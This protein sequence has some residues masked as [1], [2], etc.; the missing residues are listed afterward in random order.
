M[1]TILTAKYYK[2]I[3]NLKSVS[4]D[5]V[6][7]PI[8][9]A[10]DRENKVYITLDAYAD[11]SGK[12]NSILLKTTKSH[13]L[14]N[15]KRIGKAYDEFIR[16]APTTYNC[17]RKVKMSNV[18]ICAEIEQT[19]GLV[20]DLYELYDAVN[21]SKNGPGYE[22]LSRTTVSSYNSEYD[23]G[24]T[25]GIDCAAYVSGKS[26]TVTYGD[27]M[28]TEPLLIALLEIKKICENDN[29]NSEIGFF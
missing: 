9:I 25:D 3:W 20:L 19:H 16:F 26:C 28:P 24:M 17:F 15:V 29:G 13:K 12:R 14:D 2:T 5:G 27:K 8:G 7:I 1:A 6:D 22:L 18:E 11:H 21:K 23:A 10:C 4:H